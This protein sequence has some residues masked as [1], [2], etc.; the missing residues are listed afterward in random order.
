MFYKPTFF[1]HRL[2]FDFNEMDLFAAINY[3]DNENTMSSS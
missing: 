3:R 1:L 2:Y